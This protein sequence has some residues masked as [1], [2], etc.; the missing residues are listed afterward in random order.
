M[1]KYHAE[2]HRFNKQNKH[3]L[4]GQ[5]T[6][7]HPVQVCHCCIPIT[8]M[9]DNTPTLSQVH[10]GV[11][12]E[13]SGQGSGYQ[14]NRSDILV[15]RSLEQLEAAC[16]LASEAEDT[17]VPTEKRQRQDRRPPCTCYARCHL[18]RPLW[19]PKLKELKRSRNALPSVRTSGDFNCVI[20]ERFVEWYRKN[21]KTTWGPTT[22]SG[23][24]AMNVT[25]CCDECE[26]VNV[27]LASC[28][29]TC[30]HNHPEL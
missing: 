29:N 13:Q 26:C 7:C 23:M 9:S 19:D 11:Q 2:C 21:H 1:H 14:D 3:V 27:F 17:D 10:S 8:I 24:T 15:K 12:S 28:H 30:D 4:T 25:P 22:S 18:I 20:F 6:G 5:V 16:F